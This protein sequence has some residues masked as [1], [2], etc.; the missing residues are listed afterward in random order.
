MIWWRWRQS[1]QMT[2]WKCWSTAAVCQHVTENSYMDYLTWI[3]DFHGELWR[4]EHG[5]SSV[6][7]SSNVAWRLK[8]PET[9]QFVYHR[10]H[11]N[12]KEALKLWSAIR[13]PY[14]TG[15]EALFKRTPRHLFTIQQTPS[16]YRNPHYKPKTVWWPS[17]VYNGNRYTSKTV[18]SATSTHFKWELMLYCL[19]CPTLN[20][21]LLLLLFVVN[22]GPGGALVKTIVI[23]SPKNHSKQ[24]PCVFL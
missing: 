7:D 16:W 22:R 12:K 13:Q 2:S 15:S 19:H 8:S 20:K 23:Q 9:R 24:G 21:V 17:Q 10:V 4:E 5:V 11:A 14:F 6:S 1:I 3:Q 18:S